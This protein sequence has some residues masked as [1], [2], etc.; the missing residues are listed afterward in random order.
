MAG[1]RFRSLIEI[2]KINPYVLVSAARAARLKPGWRRPMPVRIRVNGKPQV[3]WRINL[4][5][6]GDGSFYLYLH[7]NVRKASGTRVG[8]VVSV[9]IAFDAEYR[10]GPQPMPAWFG[11]ALERNRR[12]NKAWQA[13]TP[14]RQK[15]I[16]RYLSSLKS[17]GAQ[18]RNTRRAVLVL[19]GGKERFMGRP[20]N[21]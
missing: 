21:V 3:P 1:L 12:A 19:T 11:A 20:W 13:L 16:V 17:R 7:G 9:E 6:I 8:D 4:M 15:E 10:G 5:P 18:E 2:N 14:S